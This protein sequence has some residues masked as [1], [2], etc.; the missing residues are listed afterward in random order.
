MFY[1]R[2]DQQG[3]AEYVSRAVF[4]LTPHLDRFD[5]IAVRGISGLLIGAP[6]SLQLG[7]VLVV[8]RKEDGSHSSRPVEQMGRMGHRVLFLD[9][10]VSTGDT[11]AAVLDA[12]GEEDPYADL[13][14]EYLYQGWGDM[15]DAADGP[16]VLR[17]YEESLR[18]SSAYDARF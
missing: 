4:T 16:G 15:D 7:K 18:V 13:V 5:S 9:D 6:V 11:R 10:F 17:F 3:F 14:G 12:I 1:G 8:I 2:H